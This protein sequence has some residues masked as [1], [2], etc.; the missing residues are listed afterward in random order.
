MRILLVLSILFLTGCLGDYRDVETKYYK[1]YCHNQLQTSWA[2][3]LKEY[4]T[5][6]TVLKLAD[7][8][9][10]T[11]YPKNVCEVYYMTSSWD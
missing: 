4:D 5:Y 9:I 10:S 7:F 8:F 1:V 11:K 2:T 3:N 6:F